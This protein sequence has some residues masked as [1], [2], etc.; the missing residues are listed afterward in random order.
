[1]AFRE[2]ARRTWTPWGLLLLGLFLA[3]GPTAVLAQAGPL[4]EGRSPAQTPGLFARFDTNR[5]KILVQLYYKKAPLT[6]T[7]FVALAEGK[8][9]KATR[10]GRYYDGLTF[11]RVI[12]D[13]MVQGGCPE[14]TGR[15]GPGYRFRDEVDTGLKHDSAGVLSMANAGPGTNGSQFFITHVPTPWLDGKHTVFGRVVQ[16]QDVVNKIKMGDTLKRVEILR[17]GPDAQGFLANQAQFDRLSQGLAAESASESILRQLKFL[18][19]GAKVSPSGLRTIVRRE[20]DGKGT[21]AK[22]AKVTAHYDGRFLDG[23]KF[24]SSRDRNEPFVFEVG[25]GKVIQA[26]DEAFS[27]MSRGEKRTLIVPPELGY[28]KSGYPGAIPPNAWLIFEVE[29]LDFEAETKGWFRR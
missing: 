15:G 27:T 20:G 28:G 4:D 29:L 9:T 3:L 23:K 13:F 22:G 24:D 12:P 6:V 10:K 2:L 19:P 25:K 21:P 8:M 14:G 26:W 7:N 17:V 11:H 5:G 1:M 16:G 18:Y